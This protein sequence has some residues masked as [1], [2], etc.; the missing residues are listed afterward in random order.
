MPIVC[1]SQVPYKYLF[2]RKIILPSRYS[3]GGGSWSMCLQHSGGG[4]ASPAGEWVAPP[5][6][7]RQF[8]STIRVVL[9]EPTGGSTTDLLLRH[10]IDFPRLSS[11]G[12]TS[13]KWNRYG[14]P[15]PPFNLIFFNTL[16]S[17][18]KRYIGLPFRNHQTL[19]SLMYVPIGSQRPTVALE[20]CI[21]CKIHL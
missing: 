1:V 13:L 7:H 20:E 4:E 16:S 12:L 5:H 2:T 6:P 9:S 3:L 11:H 8:T 14:C 17:A 15:S 10:N 18:S 21:L 19:K